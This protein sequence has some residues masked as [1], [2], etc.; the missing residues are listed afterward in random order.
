[1]PAPKAARVPPI[2]IIS[3][4]V[5]PR[6]CIKASHFQYTRASAFHGGLDIQHALD[7]NSN[8]QFQARR[9][10]LSKAWI[11][12]R[13][14]FPKCINVLDLGCGTGRLSQALAVHFDATVIGIDPSRKMLTQ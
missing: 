5:K 13:Q 4:M 14:I 6:S 8:R 1:M 2:R 9:T 12:T 7:H 11:M 10:E 3:G